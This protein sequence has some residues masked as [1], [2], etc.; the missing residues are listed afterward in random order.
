[1]HY[2]ARLECERGVSLQLRVGL[3]TGPVIVGTVGHNL[4]MDYNPSSPQS[5]R[6]EAS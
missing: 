1:M 3:N 4:R 6:S 5:K 2:S